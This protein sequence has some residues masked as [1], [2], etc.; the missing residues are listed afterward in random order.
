MAPNLHNMVEQNDND[1]VA[2]STYHVVYVAGGVEIPMASSR[3]IKLMKYF[4][5][6]H[7]TQLSETISWNVTLLSFSL[8]INE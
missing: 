4:L 7:C 1:D 2:H 5:N 6:N 8:K 3:Q